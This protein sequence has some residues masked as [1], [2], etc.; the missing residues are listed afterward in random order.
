MISEYDTA[1][2]SKK[3]SE[4]EKKNEGTISSKLCSSHY[5]LD[6][7]K[8]DVQDVKT[9]ITRFLVIQRSTDVQENPKAD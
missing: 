5:N 9:N 4:S 7:I 6:I 1:G 3:L 2:A 8:E